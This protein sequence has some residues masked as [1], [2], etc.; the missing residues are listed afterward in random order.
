M[1]NYKTWL[2]ISIILLVGVAFLGWDYM[3]EQKKKKK[4]G[5][6]TSQRGIN[7]M[8]S[9]TPVVIPASSQ[10]VSA[11][12]PVTGTPVATSVTVETTPSDM[13]A[14]RMRYGS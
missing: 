8:G 9:T 1:K 11:S 7:L 3:K 4:T 2:T 10:S 13:A 5:G 6:D 12:T 14:A